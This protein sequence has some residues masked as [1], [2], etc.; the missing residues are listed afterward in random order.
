[1]TYTSGGK[2]YHYVTILQGISLKKNLFRKSAN[3]FCTAFKNYVSSFSFI[4]WK[5]YIVSVS[6]TN[7]LAYISVLLG[8]I[9][10]MDMIS[11]DTVSIESYSCEYVGN[12]CPRLDLVLRLGWL[13]SVRLSGTEEWNFVW[14]SGEGWCIFCLMG[15]IL[16]N[17]YWCMLLWL[18]GILAD[19]ATLI[20]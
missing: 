4:A 15:I 6:D 2:V 20:W 9:V 7:A 5:K 3:S 12:L 13:A 14:C 16:L 18:W 17:W 1:M 11:P 10:F 19:S 8:N